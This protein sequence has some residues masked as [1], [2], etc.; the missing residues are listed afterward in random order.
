MLGAGLPGGWWLAVV[1]QGMAVGCWNST[2][3]GMLLL[4]SLSGE[5]CPCSKSP[6]VGIQA[7]SHPK[8]VCLT[9][10][11]HSPVLCTT[12]CPQLG[13]TSAVT[14]ENSVCSKQPL[15]WMPVHGMSKYR[16]DVAL[17]LCWPWCS[18]RAMWCL[19]PS[20]CWGHLQGGPP[21][22]SAGGYMYC[23]FHDGTALGEGYC[24]ARGEILRP[25]QEQLQQRRSASAC[26]SIKNES[27]GSEDDQTPS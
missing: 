9:P 23:I 15:G 3:G 1:P 16:P 6:S 8:H 12:L 11:G 21:N 14:L 13:S 2:P 17:V 19:S 18:Y 10:G 27:V 20:V 5:N 7:V 4:P 25:L 22:S 26:L 24:S